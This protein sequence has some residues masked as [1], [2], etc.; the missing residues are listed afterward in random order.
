MP[1]RGVH[2]VVAVMSLTAC[3][4]TAPSSFTL[5]ERDQARVLELAQLPLAVFIARYYANSVGPA[6]AVSF[7]SGFGFYNNEAL[8][9]PKA[10]LSAYCARNGGALY[11]QAGSQRSWRDVSID[12]F[13]DP[14]VSGSA[15]V[16]LRNLCD[17]SALNP[18]CGAAKASRDGAFGRFQCRAK[19]S[20]TTLW[21]TSIEGSIGRNIS[22]TSKMAEM[23]ITV[24]PV[25]R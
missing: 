7:T 16:S 13:A 25:S 9:R 6:D 12:A 8:L 17:P 14:G 2:L 15:A 3:A 11:R 4:S 10:V 20:D 22:R 19:D 24:T 21:S 1:T 5:S 23:K 18:G